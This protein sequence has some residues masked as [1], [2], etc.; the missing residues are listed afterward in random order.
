MSGFLLVL[1]GVVAGVA[2]GAAAVAVLAGRWV[3]RTIEE[4]AR[5]R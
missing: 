1:L 4:I 5:R 2:V 3:V